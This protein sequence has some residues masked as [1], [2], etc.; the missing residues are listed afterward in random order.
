YIAEFKGMPWR[1]RLVY[2]VLTGF[3]FRGVAFALLL[4][5]PFISAFTGNPPVNAHVVAFCL[6]YIPFFLLHTGI[7]LYLVQKFLI[8]Q[9]SE[10]GFWYRAGLLWVAMWWDNLCAMAKG[11]RTRRVADRVVAAKWKPVSD[12]PWR[13][14]RPHVLLAI[15]AAAAF[16]VTCLRSG[17]RETI[18]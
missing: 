4:L 18:W 5:L 14:V 16:T 15:A 8:P 7:L 10:R 6:R 2:L 12:S 9:G 17:R 3:Y 11:L 13:A 1:C